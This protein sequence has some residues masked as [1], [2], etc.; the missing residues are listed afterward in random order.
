MRWFF[1]LFLVALFLVSGVMT[2]DVINLDNVHYAVLFYIFF[3]GL[4]LV[5]YKA[6]FSEGYRRASGL[7]VS[8]ALIMFS[9]GGFLISSKIK[10]LS[11]ENCS[12]DF[13]SHRKV[14]GQAISYFESHGFCTEM[15]ILQIVLGCIFCVISLKLFL[16][17]YTH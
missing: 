3:I 1:L 9:L 2:I 11:R 5:W 12:T 15:A 6:Y 13:S 14:I 16:R 17:A 10:S 4:C 7:V 8:H